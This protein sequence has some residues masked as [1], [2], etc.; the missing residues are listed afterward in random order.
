MVSLNELRAG[1]RFRGGKEGLQGA[2]CDGEELVPS[3]T[4]IFLTFVLPTLGQ[5]SDVLSTHKK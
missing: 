5:K 1:P 4:S 3:P 2:C